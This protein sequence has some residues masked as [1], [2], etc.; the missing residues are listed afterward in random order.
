MSLEIIPNV[1][2]IHHDQKV[3]FV[4]EFVETI[5]LNSDC[6]YIKLTYIISPCI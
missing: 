3:N 2:Y 4:F 6:V 1:V 5:N